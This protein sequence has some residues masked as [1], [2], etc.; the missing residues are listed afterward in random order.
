VALLAA[1]VYA[2]ITY[3]NTMKRVREYSA[4]LVE[5]DYL[6]RQN[7]VLGELEGE[8]RQL[9]DYQ[10]Q[11]LRLAGIRP[12]MGLDQGADDVSEGEPVGSPALRWPAEGDV[13]TTFKTS[14]PGVDIGTGRRRAVVAAAAGVVVAADRDPDL[15]PRLV[16][17][18]NDTLQTVYANNELILAAVGDT[19]EAGQAIALVG[20]GFEGAAPHLHFEILEHG[21]PVDPQEYIPDLF[22][23]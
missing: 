7:A 20:S 12:G 17:A 6:R 10:E 13:I 15:G 1:A 9:I 11:M 16:L 18:H 3:V 2:T 21:Q 5:V 22:A 8:L 19:V 23:N 14:H 4:L